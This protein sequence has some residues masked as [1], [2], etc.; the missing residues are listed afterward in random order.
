MS[1]RKIRKIKIRRDPTTNKTEVLK[2]ENELHQL[3]EETNTLE[4]T[5][6]DE[7]MGNSCG[8][9][10]PRGGKCLCGKT[11]CVRCHTHC[12]GTDNPSPLG[13]GRPLCR[14]CAEHETMP[15]GTS[16]PLCSRCYGK[17]SRKKMQRTITKLLAEQAV[18]FEDT[19]D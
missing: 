15:D 9:D 4:S 1:G 8:C 13:C 18:E 5:Y 12:G 6:I 3:Q 17:F 10:E 11:S 7:E 19:D 2:S 14:D 16:L